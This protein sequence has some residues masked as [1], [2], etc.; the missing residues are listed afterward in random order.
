MSF[1][2]TT[3]K[4][5]GLDISDNSLRLAQLQRKNRGIKVQLYNEIKLPK[6]C[7]VQ[8]EIKQQT[9]FIEHLIKLIKTRSGYGKLREEVITSL[10]EAKTFLK[11]VNIP[12]VDDKDLPEKIK[13]ILP[14]HLPL[15][16]EEIYF[17]W[18]VIEQQADSS[19]LLIGASARDIVDSYNV[20]ITKAG[21]SPVVFEIE[22]AAIAR[23]L[24]EYNNNSRPQIIID[25]GA[26]RTGLFLYDH[27]LIK[28]TVNLPTSGNEITSLIAETLDLDPEKSEQAKIVCGLDQNKCHG[29]ILEILSETINELVQQILKATDFYYSNFQPADKVEQIVLCGG[30]ANFSGIAKTIQEKTGIAT[31]V[32]EPF[33]KIINPN[34]RYFSSQKSQSFVTAMGLGLRGINEKS[35]L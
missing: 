20:A 25:M 17:D 34:S 9:V 30:G 2:N 16:I 6:D 8:G 5:F 23:L 14:Q 26:N 7:L 31:A 18:Q 24:I 13:E 12:T 27:G 32:S 10:P 22:A 29:A 35:L 33:A 1:F 28:F 11:T 3:E 4:A 15:D 19:T 21:L